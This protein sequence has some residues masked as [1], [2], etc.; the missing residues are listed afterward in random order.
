MEWDTKL[1]CAMDVRKT[2]RI[3]NDGVCDERLGL[4]VEMIILAVWFR[5]SAISR[6]DARSPAAI[7]NL[8]DAIPAS[9]NIAAFQR[10]QVGDESWVLDHVCHEFSRVG[11]DVE[12]F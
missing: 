12:E 4:G 8:I 3:R 2:G 6:L 9:A 10:V 5:S 11:A 1:L 7:Y